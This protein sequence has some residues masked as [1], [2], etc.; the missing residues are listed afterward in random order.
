MI[1]NGMQI[2][3]KLWAN[4]HKQNFKTSGVTVLII[5]NV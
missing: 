4:L 5:D 3:L 1:Q 2:E